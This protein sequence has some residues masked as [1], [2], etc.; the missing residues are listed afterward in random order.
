MVRVVAF[1]VVVDRVAKRLLD[2]GTS[3]EIVDRILRPRFFAN[4]R[5]GVVEVARQLGVLMGDEVVVETDLD[6]ENR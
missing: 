1:S 5:D 2:A 4:G 6:H 3:G